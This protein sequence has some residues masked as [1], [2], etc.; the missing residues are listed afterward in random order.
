[1]K[2]YYL[3]VIMMAFF[4]VMIFS[5]L[6]IEPKTNAKTPEFIEVFG[7]E[8]TD[9]MMYRLKSDTGVD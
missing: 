8:E 9:D 7:E 5:N 4:I 2:K 1:M 3:F 6:K